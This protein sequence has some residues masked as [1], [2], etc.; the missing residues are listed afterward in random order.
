M[1][2]DCIVS[3]GDAH[4]VHSRLWCRVVGLYGKEYRPCH[5]LRA[6]V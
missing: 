5:Q 1:P 6:T 3:A 4:P 2:N